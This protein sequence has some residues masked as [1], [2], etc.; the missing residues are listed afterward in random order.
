MVDVSSFTL[1]H[2]FSLSLLTVTGLDVDLACA[3]IFIVCIFYTA[4]VRKGV[5][6]GRNIL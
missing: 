4:A 5:Q 2:P 3:I 1:I 6:A